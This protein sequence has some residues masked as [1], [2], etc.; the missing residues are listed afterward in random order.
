MKGCVLSREFLLS[1]LVSARE[2]D[3]P[4]LCWP[5]PGSQGL[6]TKSKFTHICPLHPV[7]PRGD[8]QAGVRKEAKWRLP[9]AKP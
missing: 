2:P 6:R 7:S 3:L 4:F 5:L 9:E 8:G 1:S